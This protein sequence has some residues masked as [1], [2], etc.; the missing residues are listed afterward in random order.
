MSGPPGTATGLPPIPTPADGCAPALQG[1]CR[2]QQLSTLDTQ[3]ILRALQDYGMIL[4]DTGD[5]LNIS[6]SPD[7]RWNDDLCWL[8]KRFTPPTSRWWILPA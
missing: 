5:R 1:E 6:G 7:W 4:A 3:V 2:P 8:W